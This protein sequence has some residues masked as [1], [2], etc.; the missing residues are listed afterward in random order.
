[1]LSVQEAIHG[2]DEQPWYVYDK[3]MTELF[4][5]D[6]AAIRESAKQYFDQALNTTG[7]DN[8]GKTAVQ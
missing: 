8:K 7:D 2:T 6:W 4:G 1:M 5:E 3:A